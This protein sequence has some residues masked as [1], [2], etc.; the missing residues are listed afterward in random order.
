MFTRILLL[1][2]LVGCATPS[3][4][5]GQTR[6]WETVVPWRRPLTDDDR[7]ANAKAIRTYVRGMVKVEADSDAANFAY[8]IPYVSGDEHKRIEGAEGLA[9][10]ALVVMNALPYLTS[11]Y[12]D[13]DEAL[14]FCARKAA[15]KA[16]SVVL[17]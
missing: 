7:L 6:K 4:L 1:T 15:R 14:F 8:P 5:P 16:M 12:P 9:L 13:H 10:Q 11:E 17:R 3:V 2:C